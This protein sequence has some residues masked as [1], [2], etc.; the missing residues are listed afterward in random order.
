MSIE[1]IPTKEGFKQAKGMVNFDGV[2]FDVDRGSIELL[3]GD[4]VVAVYATSEH[5][6]AGVSTL[7]LTNIHGFFYTPP[8]AIF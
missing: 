2:R 8:V 4:A 7:T 6:L 3:S 5:N 1:L